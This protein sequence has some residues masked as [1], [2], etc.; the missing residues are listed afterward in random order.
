[1][2]K[3]AVLLLG[4]IAFV[5]SASGCNTVYRGSV[6][7]AEGIKSGAKQDWRDA[8]EADAWMRKKL[9]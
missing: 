6:G 7:A 2:I 1:M 4:L 3:G 9:W 5:L 8:Q